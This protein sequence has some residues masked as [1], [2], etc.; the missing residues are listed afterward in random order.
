M[1]LKMVR[2]YLPTILRI[3]SEGYQNDG[4]SICDTFGTFTGIPAVFDI[5]GD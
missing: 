3:A 5:H 4:T 1:Y 2:H